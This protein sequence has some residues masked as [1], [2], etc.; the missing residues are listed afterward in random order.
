MCRLFHHFL[1]G[2]DCDRDEQMSSQDGSFS[3]PKKV[4]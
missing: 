2:A 3:L 4:H 1:A